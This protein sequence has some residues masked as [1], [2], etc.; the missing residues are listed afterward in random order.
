[1]EWTLSNLHPE[2]IT[3]PSGSQKQH[4]FIV[5]HSVTYRIWIA[6]E[7]YQ[8]VQDYWAK[9]GPACNVEPFYPLD[10]LERVLTKLKDACAPERPSTLIRSLADLDSAIRSLHPLLMEYLAQDKWKETGQ[11]LDAY[12]KTEWE[13]RSKR[14]QNVFRMPRHAFA[15]SEASA[16]VSGT[17]FSARRSLFRQ[18]T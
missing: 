15:P 18:R 10:V 7:S 12:M 6:M 5:L 4:T 14:P 2:M 9:V 16:Q 8:G 1:M 3:V 13:G 11:Q 17:L